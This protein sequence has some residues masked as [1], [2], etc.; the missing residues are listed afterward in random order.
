MNEISAELQDVLMKEKRWTPKAFN[1]LGVEIENMSIRIPLWKNHAR[2]FRM[3][4]TKRKGRVLHPSGTVADLF[5]DYQSGEVFLVE[6]EWDVLAAVERGLNHT[7]CG[8]NGAGCFNRK[9]AKALNGKSVT[10]IYD[11][12]LAGAR[13]SAKAAAMLLS[14]NCEVRNISLE[15]HVKAKGDLREFL[16]TPTGSIEKLLKIIEGFNWM[17]KEETET[18]KT[19]ALIAHQLSNVKEEKTE[20]IWQPR[21][22]KGCP[23]VLVGDPGVGKSYLTAWIA[24]QV[25]KGAPLTLDD[26]NF[27]PGNVLI[28]NMEDSLT[29]TIVGRVRTAGADLSKVWVVNDKVLL[30]IEGMRAIR[31]LIEKYQPALVVFDP[32]TSV[33]GSETQMNSANDVRDKMEFFIE[34]SREFKLAVLVVMHSN[35]GADHRDLIHRALGSIDFV[36]A[37]RSMMLVVKSPGDSSIKLVGHVKANLT[38]PASTLFYQISET[39]GVQMLESRNESLESILGQEEAQNRNQGAVDEAVEH[40]QSLLKDGPLNSSEF[41]RLCLEVGISAATIKRARPLIAKTR[42]VVNPSKKRGAGCAYHIT[43]LKKDEAKFGKL[44][45]VE[46]V[47][48][49][50]IGSADEH[51]QQSHV[52]QIS[53]TPEES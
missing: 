23:T 11:N 31:S 28:F 37:V 21:I 53:L 36:G 35:K 33:I 44:E 4:R 20:F 14:E 12:D 27:A 29:S 42:K 2:V 51:F 10:I 22:P 52:S 47:E 19:K 3:D 30:S 41:Q 24:A 34:I 50:G 32:L 39:E 45:H 18:N 17:E 5:G 48:K 25:T 6:G 9:M 49:F 13:G 16:N 26:S 46:L 1:L 38:A 15:G 8:T 7:V 43:Y 40:M